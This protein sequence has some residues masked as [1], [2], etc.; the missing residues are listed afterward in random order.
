[1]ADLGGPAGKPVRLKQGWLAGAQTMLRNLSL[2]IFIC[3]CVIG[4]DRRLET[5]PV[6]RNP[7]IWLACRIERICNSR[8][9]VEH[10]RCFLKALS[11]QMFHAMNSCASA[12]KGLTDSPNKIHANHGFLL[13]SKPG[14][15]T[16]IASAGFG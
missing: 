7:E 10:A 2:L 9:M 11:Q 3:R 12:A 4:V 1:M 16:P 6:P 5:R 8:S 15:Y 14:V 13:R